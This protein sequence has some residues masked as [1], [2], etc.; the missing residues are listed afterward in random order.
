MNRFTNRNFFVGYC[1]LALLVGETSRSEILHLDR[2]SAKSF[3]YFSNFHIQ[4]LTKG[5]KAKGLSLLEVI[6]SE[7]DFNFLG[8][9]TM[10]TRFFG[11]ASQK[12]EVSR[13]NLQ[14]DLMKEYELFFPAD[15]LLFAYGLQQKINSESNNID[16]GKSKAITNFSNLPLPLR[17]WNGMI[18][19]LVGNRIIIVPCMLIW[20]LFL[21]ILSFRPSHP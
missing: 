8:S 2:N 14:V 13:M 20:I 12:E 4:S 11:M 7:F 6:F 3:S 10:S 19:F 9:Q 5:E 15:T 16:V 21:F 1:C 18:T 17:L